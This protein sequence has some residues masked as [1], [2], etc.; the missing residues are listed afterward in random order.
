MEGGRWRPAFLSRWRNCIQR[1]QAEVRR[2]GALP[3]SAVD[4]LSNFELGL[5]PLRLSFPKMDVLSSCF[6]HYHHQND[7]QHSAQDSTVWWVQQK[8]TSDLGFN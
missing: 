2:P 8:D 5:P 1:G 6:I 3:S 7:Q 4:A